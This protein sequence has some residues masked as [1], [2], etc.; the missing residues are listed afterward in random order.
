MPFATA[1]VP[2]NLQWIGVGRE[3]TAAGTAVLPSITI[4][5]EKF[6]PDDK[7]TML[8]DKSLRGFMGEDYGDIQGTEIAD[9]PVTGD[10]YLD[11]MGH[12]LLNLWGDYQAVGSTPTSATTVALATSAGATSVVVGVIGSIVVGSVLQFG[13]AAIGTAPTENLVVS[14]V[15]GTTV[16]FANT[17]C[18][19]N[20]I[21]GAAI[22][23]VTAPFTHT[24]ALL[25]PVVPSI[26]T[27]VY[28]QPPTHTMTY[29]NDLAVSTLARQYAYWCASGIDFKMNSEQLFQHD[30]KGMA[31]LGAIAA[32]PP[33]NTQGTALALPNWRFKVGI[34]GPASG[35]T[36]VNTVQDATV[37][38]ARALK[39]KWTLQGA[40]TPWVIARLG[41]SITGKLTFVAQDESPL[42]ALLANTQQQLQLTMTNGLAGAALLAC[43]FNFNL[44]A[45]ERAP[46]SAPDV[47]TYEVDF[48]ALMN[49][50]NAGATGG[51]SPGNV[52][53]QNAIAT[54]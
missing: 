12:L 49:S 10:V 28:A 40:Q 35:G 39:P 15:A 17:P 16:T 14:A 22:A 9:L 48:R 51:L 23:I 5:A 33:T 19:F 34:G 11:A 53:I 20:H 43:T 4:P 41:M 37:S 6:Q 50:T 21:A 1:V 30:T 38:I 32:S 46:I 27:N 24:F 3:I 36:L 44:V 47:L 31:V 8:V 25:N 18:R 2:G 42:L 52:V 26:G 54:Y 7:P 29:F 45:Y 13:N